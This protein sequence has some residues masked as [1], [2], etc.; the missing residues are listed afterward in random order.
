MAAKALKPSSRSNISIRTPYRTTCDNCM[1]SKV[2]CSKDHPSCHRCRSQGVPCVYSRSRKL[3]RIIEQR[4]PIQ[5]AVSTATGAADSSIIGS[6]DND[7]RRH[8]AAA[9]LLDGCIFPASVPS[10]ANDRSPSSPWSV[11]GNDGGDLQDLI[12]NMTDMEALERTRLP[13]G[14]FSALN[15]PLPQNLPDWATQQWSYS[16]ETPTREAAVPLS[17]ESSADCITALCT[18]SEDTNSTLG[19]PHETNNTAGAGSIED[20]GSERSCAKIA[21]SIL[22]SLE[23]PGAPL[24]N[25]SQPSSA[26]HGRLLRDLDAVIRTNKAAIEVLRRISGCTCSVPGNHLVS[27]SAVL[28][29]VLAWYEACLGACD[30]TYEQGIVRAASGDLGASEVRRCEPDDGGVEAGTTRKKDSLDVL[31]CIPPIQVGSLELDAESRRKVVA[32]IVFSELAK[33]TKEIE[34]LTAGFRDMSSMGI[35][36]HQELEAQLQFSLQAAL[37]T[38]IERISQAAERASK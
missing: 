7:A 17:P 18:S 35:S 25:H 9:P 21:A 14:A 36:R 20:G 2:R 12:G 28:F 37:Q 13:T 24:K 5:L 19:T 22:Q 3:K 15:E 4:N 30:G 16:M 32:R 26:A 6:S 8:S 1:R 11:F 27:I 10:S 23:S 31:V 38:R 34:S 29:T 33:A